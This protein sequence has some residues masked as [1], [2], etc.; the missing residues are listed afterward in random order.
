MGKEQKWDLIDEFFAERGYTQEKYEA[1]KA[2]Q[3]RENSF[4]INPDADAKA[5]YTRWLKIHFPDKSDEDI[6]RKVDADLQDEAL[7][8]LMLWQD[9]ARI[10]HDERNPNGPTKF[11]ELEE[12]VVRKRRLGDYNPP[13]W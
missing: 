9:T 6:Q 8:E 12:H 11:E 3:E 4:E 10:R 2:R 1:D 13:R 5:Y 7:R